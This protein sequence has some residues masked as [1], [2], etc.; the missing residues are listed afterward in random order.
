MASYSGGTPSRT[1]ARTKRRWPVAGLGSQLTAFFTSAPI[2]ASPAAV[3]SVRAKEVGHMAPSSRFAL[4]LKPS[5]APVH[6]C[7]LLVDLLGRGERANQCLAPRVIPTSRNGNSF[8]NRLRIG[9]E[10]HSQKR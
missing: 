10:L 5:V 3:N 2:L 6:R 9:D 4:S 1:K 8:R 7:D